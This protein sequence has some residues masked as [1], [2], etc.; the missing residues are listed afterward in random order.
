MRTLPRLAGWTVSEKMRWSNIG[1]YVWNQSPDDPCSDHEVRGNQV[2]YIGELGANPSWDAGNCGE[3]AGWDDNV[4]G[5][6]TARCVDLRRVVPRVRV[7][8]SA[9]PCDT[10][11]TPQVCS[12]TAAGLHRS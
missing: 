11:R 8:P 12:D 7:A 6:E 3:V 2:F 5:D 1:L 10:P 9:V 4:W